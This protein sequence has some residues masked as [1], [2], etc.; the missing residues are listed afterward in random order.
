MDTINPDDN[1][2]PA[3]LMQQQLLAQAAEASS[4][5]EDHST[6]NQSSQYAVHNTITQETAMQPASQLAVPHPAPTTQ[7]GF[8]ATL[9]HQI[10]R[11]P[12]IAMPRR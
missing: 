7:H 4:S 9:C 6:T 3:A 1:R 8:L 5:N 2:K 11:V 12:Q 10:R